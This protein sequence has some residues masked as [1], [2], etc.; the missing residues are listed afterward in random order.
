VLCNY[1]FIIMYEF[2]LCFVVNDREFYL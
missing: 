1:E 2:I